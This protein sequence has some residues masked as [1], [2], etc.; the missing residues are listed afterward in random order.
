MFKR[1]DGLWQE[2]FQ[3][4]E[5][6]KPKYFYSSEKTEKKAR[7]DINNQIF[8]YSSEQHYNKHNFK[9]LCEK[10]LEEKEK[11]VSFKTMESYYIAFH[12]L[13]SLFEYD[14]ENIEPLMIEN[15][16]N[17]LSALNY[18]Y[19]YIH[20]IKI[21]LSIVFN[22]AIRQNIKVINFMRTIS[23][24]K[25]AHKGKIKSPDNETIDFIKEKSL[26]THFGFWSLFILATG[27]RKGEANAVQKKDINF[28][29]KTISITKS[30]AFQNNKPVIKLPKTE[31]GIRTVPLLHIL[32]EP[33]KKHCKNLKPDDFI[34]GGKEPLTNTAIRYNFIKFRKESG[35]DFNIHQ[36]RH[37]YAKLLYM[38]G[39]D[40]KTAQGLLGHSDIKITM[41]IYTD[42]D[43]SMNRMAQDKLNTFLSN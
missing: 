21:F 2:K 12:R 36:L 39:I 17:S 29:S 16:F 3:T 10:A 18:S 25:N 42:F 4:N 40:P 20:K 26:D 24:P 35:C 15:I 38:A 37:A 33:L 23:V 28:I 30:T 22:Y 8:N 14:I 31:N 6:V 1:K 5:M 43:N 11:Q 19:S 41:N 9:M 27:M 34:F 13:T 7:Q 32:E